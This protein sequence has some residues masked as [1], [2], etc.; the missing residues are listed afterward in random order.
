LGSRIM[1]K[2][3]GL[4]IMGKA[5]GSL[6]RR[7]R[8]VGGRLLKTNTEVR[9]DRPHPALP[10]TRPPPAPD[11]R[12]WRSMMERSLTQRMTHPTRTLQRLEQRRLKGGNRKH[13]KSEQRRNRQSRTSG[14]RK[15]RRNSR[16]KKTSRHN[17]KQEQETSKWPPHG[18]AKRQRPT[19]LGPP[20]PARSTLVGQTKAKVLQVRAV[21]RA[22]V[23]TRPRLTRARRGDWGRRRLR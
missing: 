15:Q 17:S 6:V 4:G 16:K 19:R 7:P 5:L 8:T 14:I 20:R 11:T 9:S 2:A 22:C 18:L 21:A 10:P 23:R 13:G 3:L 12:Q 1:G